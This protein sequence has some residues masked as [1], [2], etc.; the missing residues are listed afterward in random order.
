MFR[1]HA[2]KMNVLVLGSNGMLGH[3]VVEMLKRKSQLKSSRIG[4]VIG[5]DIQDGIDVC[6]R[7]ELGNYFMNSIHYDYCINCIAYTDTGKAESTPE[8]RDLDYKLN[9]LAPKYIAESCAYWKTKL[10]HISTD[11]VFSQNS[12]YSSKVLDGICPFKPEDEPFPVNT[13]G[14]NKL[15][16][17]QFIKEEF[18]GKEKEFAILRT[19]WLYGAHNNKSFIHKFIKN[20]VK[21]V[22]SKEKDA[23]AE[24]TMTENE[25][26]VPTS[27][28][29]VAECILDTM[30]Q[31]KHG[32]MHAVCDIDA[33]SEVNAPH[34]DLVG[35]AYGVTR[36]EFAKEILKNFS[37][38]QFVI[39]D[40]KLSDVNVVP[41][42]RDTYQ[43]KFSAMKSSFTRESGSMMSRFAW[44]DDLNDFLERNADD[45]FKWAEEQCS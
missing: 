44:E 15:I 45:I 22:L 3:D 32:V 23:E 16:G 21:V 29:F 5:L 26:S 2:K 34:G 25:V 43:P 6:K 24:V 13:Y 10:I 40:V 12:S 33:V 9:A 39:N 36:V 11:Y 27:T 35:R 42:E 38:D 17:E 28:K 1:D 19:S 41:V 7:H 37:Y 14:K 8:G 20:V 31:K 30:M 18:K 4:V